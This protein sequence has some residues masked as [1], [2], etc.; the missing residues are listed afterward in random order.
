MQESCELL[1][2]GDVILIR[3]EQE[4]GIVRDTDNIVEVNKLDLG[5]HLS[6]E[7]TVDKSARSV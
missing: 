1:G 6:E 3:S 5:L 2:G 7:L 4:A